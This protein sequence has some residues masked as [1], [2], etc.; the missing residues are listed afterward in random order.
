MPLG[1]EGE[2]LVIRTVLCLTSALLPATPD[3]KAGYW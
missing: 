3:C 1:M 2:E